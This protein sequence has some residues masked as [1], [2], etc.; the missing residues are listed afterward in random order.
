MEIKT[1][2]AYDSQPLT[3]LSPIIYLLFANAFMFNPYLPYWQSTLLVALIV[4]VGLSLQKG[5]FQAVNFRFASLLDI[6]RA[7]LIYFFAV[8]SMG[9][10]QTL[11][12]TWLV[13]KQ[14][15]YTLTL[16]LPSERTGLLTLLFQ[17][18][19]ITA[20]GE[21]LYFRSFVY[22]QLQRAGIKGKWIFISISA[23]L[24]CMLFGHLAM[25]GIV[26]GFCWGIIM[27]LVYHRYTNITINIVLHSAVEGT[28]LVLGHYK[29]LP[30]KIMI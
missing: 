2:V 9:A 14:L 23:L 1:S 15:K 21:E 28:L 29:L 20:I 17:T 5:A 25:Y 22:T 8:C 11:D 19:F 6:N 24:Y 30:F 18:A 7:M 10:L 12:N 16:P 26:V 13:E 27:A 4:L 3:K